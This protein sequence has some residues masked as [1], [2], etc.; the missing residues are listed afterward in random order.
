MGVIFD[1]F[2]MFDPAAKTLAAAGG[3]ALGKLYNVSKKLQGVGFN[4][5]TKL[6]DSYIDPIILYGASVWGLKSFSYPDSTQNRAIR[7][8][9]GV[10]RFAAN[11]A[12]NADMG[13]V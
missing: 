13:V 10:H 6:Y 7:M 8:F 11:A 4:T 9:L 1:E 12:V 2:L 5:Y 3:R